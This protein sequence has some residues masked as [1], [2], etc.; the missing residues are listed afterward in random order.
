MLRFTIML[1]GQK[2]TEL[3]NPADSLP[4]LAVFENGSWG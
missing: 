4:Q 2:T 1:T 3:G